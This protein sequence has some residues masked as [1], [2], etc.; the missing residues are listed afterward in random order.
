MESAYLVVIRP[1]RTRL[2]SLQELTYTFVP[3]AMHTLQS[4]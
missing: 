3:Y 2:S 4:V 1:G